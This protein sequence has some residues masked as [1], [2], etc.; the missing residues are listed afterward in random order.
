MIN[1]LLMVVT[2]AIYLA[3]MAFAIWATLTII[4][5][6]RRMADA[7]ERTVE[8]LRGIEERLNGRDL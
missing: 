6:Q 2:S 5:T 3:G 1:F 7:Q 8:V 4:E